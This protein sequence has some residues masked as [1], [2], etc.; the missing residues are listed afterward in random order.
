[1]FLG[2]FS[3]ISFYFLIFIVFTVITLD[4]YTTKMLSVLTN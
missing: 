2:V 3:S 4:F 1:M